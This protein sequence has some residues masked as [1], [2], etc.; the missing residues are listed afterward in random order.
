MYKLLL[1]WRY[2]RTRYLALASI[3]SMML[4]VATLI[5]VNSVM[6]GF[7]TQLKNKLHGV[8]ADILLEARSMNDG[9]TDVEGKMQAVRQLVGDRIAGM[10]PVIDGFAILEFRINRNGQMLSK[11]VRVVGVDPATN[12]QV[13]EFA[14]YLRN[15]ANQANPANCFKVEGPIAALHESNYPRLPYYEPRPPQRLT[16]GFQQPPPPEPPELTPEESKLF[17]AVVGWGMA[18]YRSHDAKAGDTNVDRPLMEPGDEIT[19]ILAS[20]SDLEAHDGSRGYPK[21]VPARFVIT[22][23][24]K[25]EMSEFDSNTVYLDIKDVQRLRTMHERATSLHI[26]LKDYDRDAREVVSTLQAHFHPSMFIV[27]TW[28][29]KQGPIL[30]AIAIERGILNVL[31]FLIIAVAGF[32]ILAIFF[33]I[34]V[35]KA[36]DIGVL[37]ALGASN[38]GVMGIFLS[39]GL[40]LGIVGAGLGTVLGVSITVYINE[41]ERML[42][43]VTGHDVF[44][45]DVYYFDKI[46]TDL[47][48]IMVVLVVIGALII[49]VGASVLPSL[50]AA[51]LRPVQALRFE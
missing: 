17:G 28:E 44:S 30:S 12:W 25:S 32:G 50:R 4:G 6:E 14:K 5:V 8:Q 51:M 13:G 27:E 3:I 41:I 35:E 2:L 46:P 49:A 11:T 19:L 48:P 40:G 36:R 33:M 9:M 10:S 18:T 22:D 23:L 21:P 43:R 1:S 47:Q 20:R 31:L 15:P 29:Q 39:Y 42:A 38:G 37:K 26:K 7:A 34:V 45:R 16:N 24:S